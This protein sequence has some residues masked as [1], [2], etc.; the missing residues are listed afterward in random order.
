MYAI[1]KS[2]ILRF[3]RILYDKLIA[4]LQDTTRDATASTHTGFEEKNQ[5]LDKTASAYY[6]IN[7]FL[8]AFIDH[9]S[10]NYQIK[11]YILLFKCP[12]LLLGTE[13]S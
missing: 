3:F 2:Y 10:D 12:F 13:R 11:Y 6:N 8:S 1:G 5:H 7:R 4:S 9:V